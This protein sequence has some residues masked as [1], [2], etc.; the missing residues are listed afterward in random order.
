MQWVD[1]KFEKNTVFTLP[2]QKSLY[3]FNLYHQ[4]DSCYSVFCRKNNVDP[5]VENL[6]AWADI[7]ITIFKFTIWEVWCE[8][9]GSFWL[10][11]INKTIDSQ[12]E[13]SCRPTGPTAW[14]WTIASLLGRPSKSFPSAGHRKSAPSSRKWIPHHFFW[15]GGRLMVWWNV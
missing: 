15:G 4:H 8:S 14:P 5:K 1:I 11:K 9:N 13:L 10:Q 12:F 2:S 7:D 6:P 3:Y